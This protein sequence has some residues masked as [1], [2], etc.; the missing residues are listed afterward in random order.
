MWLPRQLEA[1]ERSHRPVALHGGE[2]FGTPFLVDALRARHRLAWF[3]LGPRAHADPVAQANALAAALNAA[4]GGP[5]FGLGLPV[6]AHLDALRHHEADLAPLW[7]VA[8]LSVPPPPWLP[9]LGALHGEAFR[10]LVDLRTPRVPAGLRRWTALRDREALAVR[11]EEAEGVVPR[12]VDAATLDALLARTGGRFGDLLLESARAASLP[13]PKVP[14]PD[15]PLLA[16]EEGEAVPP[17]L[18]ARAL[19]LQGDHVGALEL[20]VLRAP[21]LVDDLLRRAGPAYQERGLVARLHLLLTALPAPYRTRERVLEWRLVAAAAS[22]ALP[23]V[24]EEVDAHLATFS[25]PELRARRAGVLPVDEGFS[26][27]AAA[28]GARRTPLTLWQF[29]RLHP[30]R[31]RGAMLLEEAVRLAEEAGTPYDLA[32]NAG[33]LAARLLHLG[34]FVRARAWAQWALQSFDRHG[35][36]DG[37]R[38]LLLVNDLALARVLTGDLAG[39][40]RV[41]E[42]GAAVLDGALPDVAGYYRST[43]AAYEL[44][45]GRPDAAEARL[46]PALER[47]PLR[48]R[49][50]HAA[51]MVRVLH[52]LGCFDEAQRVGTEAFELGR[53][54]GEQPRALGLLARGMAGAVAAWRAGV[55][56]GAESEAAGDD[57]LEVAI[58]PTL[59]AEHRLPA[60]LHLLLVR[61]AAAASL[62]ADL[63]AVLRGLAPSAVRVFAGPAAAFGR[64]ADA[65]SGG[66]P[67]LRLGL[68][69]TPRVD[70]EGAPVALSPRLLELALALALHPDGVERDVL[71]AFLTYPGATPFTSGGLRGLTTRL[72]G[73]LPVSD[74]P[75]RFTVAYE[76][77]LLEVRAQLAAGRVRD[78]VALLRG[79]LLP[80]SEAP[81]VVE[82]RGE[83]E[84]HLR[85]AALDA[86]DADVLFELAERFADDLELWEAT[87]A[88]LPPG[89]PRLALARARA[90]RLRVEYGV[91]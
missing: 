46:R 79:P 69:G 59:A 68:L 88:A 40:E 75:Y 86:A 89:D 4:A 62:P 19:A 41:L 76:A 38:R 20:A 43:W 14:G 91:T 30:D 50:E 57:L 85:Q 37:M 63:D 90:R 77:D 6:R 26:M 24:V 51:L 16:E 9:D 10:V 23:D 5:L 35:L 42:D 27:A 60:A 61:P 67:P 29:G 13:L 52:E 55:L 44:A 54:A 78:A 1:I 48:A 74:A 12:A 15:G 81:G 73:L 71:N 34:E 11:R 39:L 45:V 49:A 65:V 83:L 8:T 3:A 72:R 2:P 87:A 32:R 7:I 84:D 21:E 17:A 70:L 47:S 31:R 36:R 56:E 80:W 64:V 66:G 82:V 25:A 18:A 28:A 33:A 58:A 22:A 53:D